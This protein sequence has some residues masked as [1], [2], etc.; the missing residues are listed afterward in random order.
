[1]EPLPDW[2][3]SHFCE[4]N[5]WRAVQEP[6]LPLSGRHALFI[7]NPDRTV[8]LWS[9][10]AGDE[11]EGGLVVWDFHVV[12]L[13]QGESGPLLWDPDCTVATLQPLA[14]WLVATFPAGD[15][16]QPRF[17]PRFRKVEGGRLL[18]TFASDRSHMRDAAGH[19]TYPPPRHPAPQGPGAGT[20]MNLDRFLDMEA[21]F[22][23]ELLGLHELAALAGL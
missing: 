23:G 8:A 9:Q 5:V 2:Y 6:A 16:V 1:M 22:E 21:P 7:S 12:M 10:R 17:L 15:A 14:S 18:E 13:G 11:E 19:F 3:A 20:T 4:E